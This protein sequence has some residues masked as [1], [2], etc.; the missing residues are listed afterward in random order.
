MRRKYPFR[1]YPTIQNQQLA[2]NKQNR[3]RNVTEKSN[4]LKSKEKTLKEVLVNLHDEFQA[5]NK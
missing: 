2:V 1:R 5:L 3:K 4:E